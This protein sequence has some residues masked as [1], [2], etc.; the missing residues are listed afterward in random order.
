[1]KTYDDNHNKVN[2]KQHYSTATSH[3]T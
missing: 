3:A 2:F 1:M